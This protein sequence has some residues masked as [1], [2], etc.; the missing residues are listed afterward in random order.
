[1]KDDLSDLSSRNDIE[2]TYESDYRH[3]QG[4]RKSDQKEDP[5]KLCTHLTAKLL[6]KDSKAKNFRFKM[7]EDPLQCWISFLRFV[8]SLEMIFHNTQK[9]MKYF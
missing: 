7:Y 5:I 1:M 8:E 4:K 3:N 6:T 9:L 2:S